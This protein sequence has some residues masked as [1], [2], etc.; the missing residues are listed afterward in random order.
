ML[1]AQKTDGLLAAVANAHYSETFTMDATM[2]QAGHEGK[3]EETHRHNGT[4]RA[5]HA[6]HPADSD[7]VGAL[8]LDVEMLAE[9]LVDTADTELARLRGQ[10]EQSLE[11]VRQNLAGSSAS[12]RDRASEAAEAADDFVRSQLWPTIGLVALGAAAIGFL[13]GRRQ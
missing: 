5:A 1:D 2:K 7:V 9:R 3:E 12:F 11:A 6:R 8:I 10:V 4:P 13:A